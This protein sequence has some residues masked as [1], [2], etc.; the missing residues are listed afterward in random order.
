MPE[1]FG[2]GCVKTN[3]FRVAC[4]RV[5]REAVKR[6]KFFE[7]NP[8]LLAAWMHYYNDLHYSSRHAGNDYEVWENPKY[9]IIELEDKVGEHYGS[10]LYD[11]WGAAIHEDENRL[12]GKTLPLEEKMNKTVDD[13]VAIK[14]NP[15]YRFKSLYHTRYQVLSTILCSIGSGYTWNKD[16]F[17]CDKG[18]AGTDATLYIG[19]EKQWKNLPSPLQKLIGEWYADPIIKKGARKRWLSYQKQRKEKLELKKMSRDWRKLHPIDKEKE[20]ARQAEWEKKKLPEGMSFYPMCEYSPL[21]NM[22]RNAHS[23][24]VKAAREICDLI[25][26]AEFDPKLA[27]EHWTKGSNSYKHHEQS[28]VSNKKIA[29]KFLKDWADVLEGEV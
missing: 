21:V 14:L 19:Y 20:A 2:V 18:T 22:P 17:V 13:W 9:P 4:N 11:A 3:Q 29:R 8:K 15:R 10:L 25:M 28:L 16:G 24:Y 27:R 1:A 12:Y 7:A 6:Q 23:S 26:A 5:L